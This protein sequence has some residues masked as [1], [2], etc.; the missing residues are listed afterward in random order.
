MKIEQIIVLHLIKNKQVTLQG[1]GTFLLDPSI[2]SPLENPLITLPAHAITFS[3]DANAAEDAALVDSIV[4]YTKKLR[5]L[6]SSDL[7]SFLNWQKQLLTI[8]LPF[9]LEGI[10]VLQ[11]NALGQIVFIP[12]KPIARKNETTNKERANKEINSLINTFGIIKAKYAAKVL[13]ITF[14]IIAM[15]L[16]S[17]AAYQ[18]MSKQKSETKISQQKTPTVKPGTKAESPKNNIAKPKPL[19]KTVTAATANKTPAFKIVFYETKVQA[20]AQRKLNEIYGFGHSVTMFSND[21]SYKVAMPFNRPLTDTAYVTDSLNKYYSL[22]KG[23][24]E[25]EPDL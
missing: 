25:V 16:V 2:F 7:E 17:F 9:T 4:N 18:Y 5:P 19:V 13:K 21:S 12:D 8:N 3:Y 10:G 15:G 6:A 22:G 24:V 23:I 20:D 11:K 14:I 1:I